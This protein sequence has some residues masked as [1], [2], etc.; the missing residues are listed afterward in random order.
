MTTP[1]VPRD[2]SDV[3][4]L[5]AAYPL[6][7][8]VSGGPDD[9]LATPL[10]LLAESDPEGR[11]Q[12]LLG[13][14]SRANPQRAALEQDPRATILC[15]GPQGYISPRLV[16]NPTWGPTWNYAACRFEVEIRFVP[17]ENDSA[18]SRLAEALEG[19]GAGAWT[20][21]RMGARYEQLKQHI[22]AFR[23][24]VRQSDARFK[25]G[26]DESDE[27]F[28]EIADGLADTE[29]AEWMRRMRG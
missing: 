2:P 6:C 20:P 17:E 18:L 21:Q 14:I 10:P 23:A 13:H 12:S 1:F 15:M 16:S 24:D 27:T 11:V 8:I 5:V 29:L 26:Q 9:R 3:T 4:Q 19:K 28:A 22:V 25:L 7:W